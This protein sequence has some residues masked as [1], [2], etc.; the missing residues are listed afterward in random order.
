MMEI[1]HQMNCHMNSP[2]FPIQFL[3]SKQLTNHNSKVYSTESCDQMKFE[4]NKIFP[5]LLTCEFVNYLVADQRVTKNPGLLQT[6]HSRGQEQ[7]EGH[8]NDG[9]QSCKKVA[10]ELS[11]TYL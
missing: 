9:D 3:S 7:W 5:W 2:V 6:S 8:S 1:L 4:G 10:E 11:C